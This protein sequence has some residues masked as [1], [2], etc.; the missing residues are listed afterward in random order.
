MVL[1][2]KDST[3]IVTVRSKHTASYTMNS[4][5]KRCATVL[6]YVSFIKQITDKKP[7]IP[8][9]IGREKGRKEDGYVGR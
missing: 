7:A 5:T 3:K 9:E 6:Y 8:Q 1:G 2:K 4:R